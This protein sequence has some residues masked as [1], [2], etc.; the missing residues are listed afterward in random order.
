MVSLGHALGMQVVAEGVEDEAQLIFLRVAGVDAVQGYLF[1][2][3]VPIDRLRYALNRT[4]GPKRSA[5][6]G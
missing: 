6:I 5:L 4:E 2:K 3:A 1:G